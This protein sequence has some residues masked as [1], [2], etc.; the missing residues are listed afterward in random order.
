MTPLKNMNNV[1]KG[2]LLAGLFPDKV[3]GILEEIHKGYDYMAANEQSLR[4]EWANSLFPFEFWYRVA[5]N[6]AT[7]AKQYGK[8]LSKRNSLFADQLFD[9]YNALYTIDCIVKQSEALPE[10]PENDTYKLAVRLLFSHYI[11]AP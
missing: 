6:V 4:T 1:E 8:K 2:K 9:H 5:G 11:V 3:Q 7:A 10:L